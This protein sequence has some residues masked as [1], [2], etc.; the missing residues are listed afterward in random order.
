MVRRPTV[1]SAWEL[2]AHSVAAGDVDGDAAVNAEGVARAEA[3]CNA[4]QHAGRS[5]GFAAAAAVAD[6]SAAVQELRIRLNQIAPFSVAA[7]LKA[8]VQA[9]DKAAAGAE[10]F[11]SGKGLVAGPMLRSLREVIDGFAGAVGIAQVMVYCL[12]ASQ[13][14]VQADCEAR[15]HPLTVPNLYPSGLR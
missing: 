3:A 6:M 13:S 10:A 14:L 11:D 1:A 12:G 5:V 15:L 7:A 2:E 8:R 9:G 4:Y